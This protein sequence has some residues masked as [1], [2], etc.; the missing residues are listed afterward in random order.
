MRN[1]FAAVIMIFFVTPLAADPAVT[2]H[3]IRNGIVYQQAVSVIGQ[4]R[5]AAAAK[6]FAS[7]SIARPEPQAV[8]YRLP[9]G[10]TFTSRS[11]ILIK[12]VPS[13]RI[14][15][16]QLKQAFGLELIR[17]MHSGDYLFRPTTGDTLTIINRLLEHY[18]TRIERIGPNRKLAMQ[19]W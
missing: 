18:V 17:R 14:D 16:A 8:R 12:F 10:S 3:R 9:D 15:L 2:L 5:L 1:R 13:A 6:M 11:K 7:S 19:L 4:P